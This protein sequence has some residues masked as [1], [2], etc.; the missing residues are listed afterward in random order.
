MPQNISNA[1]I[2]LEQHTN[3]PLKTNRFYKGDIDWSGAFELEQNI[4]VPLLNSNIVLSKD[5]N[6]E[7]EN[8]FP[9]SFLVFNQ[10]ENKNYK[11]NL[12][13]YV[14]NDA[15]K[16][17][18]LQI[19]S[20][21]SITFDQQNKVV[22]KLLKKNTTSANYRYD[23]APEPV[24]E[25]YGYYEYSY[26]PNTRETTKTLLHA[27]KICSSDWSWE[28]NVGGGG[29]SG[30]TKPNDI[31]IEDKID[32]S[33]LSGKA[34]CLNDLLNKKGD[35][36]VKKLL[37]NFEG[38]SEFDIKI[39][40]QEKVFS[41]D[42]EVN[43]RT[44]YDPS[45]SNV[46]NIQISIS[47]TENYSALENAR[48]ILHEY[49]HADITRKLYTINNPPED[50]PDFKQTFESYHNQHSA[51]ANLYINSMATAL[52]NFHQNVLVNDYNNYTKYYDEEPSEDFY[53]AFAWGGLKNS[54][55]KAWIDLTNEQKTA[56]NTLAERATKLSGMSHVLNNNSN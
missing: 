52:K 37:A 8:K 7:S 18:K 42:V 54:D 2:W 11:V 35:S 38:K 48:I 14:S 44:F 4:Y 27:F 40:S 19:L 51:M 12:K 21:P 32:D 1:K 30:V 28:P 25:W 24:C 26:D 56:I 47:R 23:V 29:N 10:D 16:K 45:I 36:F 39:V 20:L 34:K 55:V 9:Y 3:L 5:N 50:Q 17:E 6:V 49:I 53:N 31:A 22:P 41:K 13:V 46:I 33:E 15:F 43:G